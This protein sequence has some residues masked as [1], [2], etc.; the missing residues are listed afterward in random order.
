MPSDPARI[1]PRLVKVAL[2]NERVRVLRVSLGPQD[3]VPIHSHPS[4]VGIFLTPTHLENTEP[5]KAPEQIRARPGEVRWFPP[6]THTTRNRG[7][8]HMEMV[9]VELNSPPL[10]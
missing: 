9:I 1:A 7:P 10:P 2:E 3:V 5:L 4:A 6:V 8:N